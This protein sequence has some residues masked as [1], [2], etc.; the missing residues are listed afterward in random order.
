MLPDTYRG[1]TADTS[2]TL[3]PRRYNSYVDLVFVEPCLNEYSSYDPAPS[4]ASPEPTSNHP[5]P[6][7]TTVSVLGSVL[8]RGSPEAE[9]GRAANQLTHAKDKSL[10]AIPRASDNAPNVIVFGETGVGKSSLINMIAGVPCA[11]VS[12]AAVGCTFES[13]P[14]D[15]EL[16]SRKF[17]LWDTV[18]LNEGEQGTISADRAIE[19]L[20]ELVSN[21]QYEGVS[22]LVYCI[23]GSRLRDIVKI[24]YDLFY[25]MICAS[26]VPVVVVVTGL[27]NEDNMEDWWSDNVVDFNSRG[28]RFSG[29]ACITTMKGK[30]VK[31]GQHMFEE[32]YSQSVTLVQ[33]VIT[34][35]CLDTSWKPD[36]SR[37]LED[38]VEIMR[39]MCVE[40]DSAGQSRDYGQSGGRASD[41]SNNGRTYNP[42]IY[43]RTRNGRLRQ[44]SMATVA[45]RAKSVFRQFLR[46]VFPHSKS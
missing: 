7:R 16:S 24:N 14:Y 4:G 13:F 8:Q 15:V 30:V 1:A 29:H 5:H 36:A 27:E 10:P 46:K 35:H 11:A 37:W 42:V 20:Q 40:S 3:S 28:M 39:R 43:A 44:Q 33:D 22:L 31:D 38:I 19:S 34:R 6:S 26:K 25:K 21:L 12:S 32:E 2:T 17:R 9:S 45:E 18:G 41:H 23:R